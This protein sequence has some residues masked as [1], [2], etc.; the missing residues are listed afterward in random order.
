MTRECFF[1]NPRILP[2]DSTLQN[3]QWLPVG[4]SRAHTSSVSGRVLT[5]SKPLG[6]EYYDILWYPHKKMLLICYQNRI[7]VDS[8][9]SHPA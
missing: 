3:L 4:L 6:T 8:K 2:G 5:P 9:R 1:A 7:L